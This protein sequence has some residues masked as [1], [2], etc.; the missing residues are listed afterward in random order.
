MVVYPI[1]AR[2]VNTASYRDNAA[3]KP[4]N[5]PMMEWFFKLPAVAE[6]AK[7]PRINLSQPT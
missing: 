1:A 5:K 2:D 7:D 6:D 3:A 4:L